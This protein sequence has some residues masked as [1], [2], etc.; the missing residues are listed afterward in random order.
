MFPPYFASCVF[1]LEFLL[2]NKEKKQLNLLAGTLHVCTAASRVVTQRVLIK[3]ACHVMLIKQDSP[4]TQH[5]GVTLLHWY[6]V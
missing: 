6:L 1:A 2:Q 4:A 3:I 5:C